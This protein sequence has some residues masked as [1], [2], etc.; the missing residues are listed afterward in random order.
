MLVAPLSVIISLARPLSTTLLREPTTTTTSTTAMSKL[1]LLNLLIKAA[2]ASSSSSS[3]SCRPSPWKQST[4]AASAL[5][6]AYEAFIVN[7]PAIAPGTIVTQRP[8]FEHTK[9]PNDEEPGIVLRRLTTPMV[10]TINHKPKPTPYLPDQLDTVV[11][12]YRRGE[13]EL[14]VHFLD[15]RRLEPYDRVTPFTEQRLHAAYAKYQQRTAVAHQ[16][17]AGDLV[18]CSRGVLPG[19]WRLAIVTERLD[20]PRVIG[21]GNL[22]D[23]KTL[24]LDNDGDVSETF[25]DSALC[26]KLPL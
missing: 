16:L 4:D 24:V 21:M 1:E 6:D 5:R 25:V 14:H 17:T 22:V 20:A 19:K 15:G 18:R 3:S 7:A 11:G 2:E 9:T 13:H 26:K 23:I 8:G 10:D 12:V